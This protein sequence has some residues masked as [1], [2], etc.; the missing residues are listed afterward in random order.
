MSRPALRFL[1]PLLALLLVAA[2]SYGP[3][4]TGGFL[5]DD[6]ANL[7]ALGAQGPIDNAAAFW[8][9][10]TA[11]AADPT[12]RPLAMLSFLI[13]GRDWP[14]DPAPFLRTNLILHLL[15]GTLLAL[16]LRRLGRCGKY[17][18]EHADRAALIGAG[19]WLLHPLLISTTLYIV[20][21]EAMLPA[22]FVLLGLISWLHGRERIRDGCTLAGAAWIILGLGAC[23]L[24]GTLC[25]ANGVLLPVFAVL[26]EH[27]L[28]RSTRP[29]PSEADRPYRTLMMY[30]GWLP[31]LLVLVYLSGVG[32][33]GLIHGIDPQRPWTL[34]QRLLTEPRV[35]IDYLGLLWLPRPYTSGLF[36]D[37]WSVSTGLL[38]P[39][40][41]LV[42]VF[43]IAAV[44]LATWRL[45][46]RYPILTL[47]VW[48]YLAGQLIE[49]TTIPL[50]IYF[51]HRNYLP[52]LVMFWPLALWLAADGRL[53]T[54]RAL[55]SLVILASLAAMT[56]AG[57]SL[58]GNQID[59]ALLWARLNPLSPRAQAFA[60]QAEMQR[61]RPDLAVIRIKQALNVHPDEPQ[62][63]LNLLQAECMTDAVD[64]QA[65][66]TA[67][68]TISRAR[69]GQRLTFQWIEQ[70]IP[71]GLQRPC[72]KLDL[73]AIGRLV[74]AA[75]R[76]PLTALQAGRRQDIQHLRGLL[77]LANHRPDEALAHFDAAIKEIPNP[78]TAAKQAALMGA[79]GFPRQGLAHLNYFSRCAHNAAR[80]PLLMPR[81]HE[82]VLERQHYWEIELSRLRDNLRHDAAEHARLAPTSIG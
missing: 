65:I 54:T 66:H 56:Y 38:T 22:T 67:A 62:L 63:A 34:A 24:L 25:K 37:Q 27:V 12:G 70:Y 6:Y 33:Q 71:R 3:G 60:A 68:G 15:N 81:L 32:L 20:Q 4:L 30:G 57:A 26:I 51:E 13:D 55:L 16:L 9:Y 59:Q 31:T 14:T 45:R 42:A 52:A 73:N 46:H 41:T 64:D 78:E 47:A 74:D 76:N 61:G 2:A 75:E 18:P 19:I 1:L 58:W 17:E 21:R 50:E 39:P 29:L 11:G 49:S 40:A 44:L 35:L 7:P 53:G 80:K 10:I 69:T 8:R 43:A 36:N 48:F 5:F 82:W 77:D 72:G 79:S 28:L 23:T